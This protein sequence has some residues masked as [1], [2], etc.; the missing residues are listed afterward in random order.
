M[1]FY[2]KCCNLQTCHAQLI[3]M[4]HVANVSR[5]FP[6]ISILAIVIYVFDVYPPHTKKKNL[7]LINPVPDPIRSKYYSEKKP[8]VCR[9]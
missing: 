2:E 7:L 5:A 3:N 1:K 6:L 4:Q 9:K 8:K